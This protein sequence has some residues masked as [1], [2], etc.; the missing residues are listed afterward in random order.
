M[1]VEPTPYRCVIPGRL[2]QIF[3]GMRSTGP[4]PSVLYGAHTGDQWSLHRSAER[5]RL[6][7]TEA[8][9]AA[10]HPIPGDRAQIEYRDSL[11]GHSSKGPV[12]CGARFRLEARRTPGGTCA[13]AAARTDMEA[14][15]TP[16]A[17]RRPAARPRPIPPSRRRSFRVGR[18]R[19]VHDR[20]R[21]YRHAATDT[22]QVRRSHPASITFPTG[23]ADARKRPALECH[24][25][26]PP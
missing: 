2:S 23:I 11:R 24:R 9:Q 22:C 20:L 14:A 15:Q 8:A 4:R 26:S 7:T 6:P 5:R 17:H 25:L 21:P 12:K 3:V 1:T 13:T 16:H 19:P 10:E 18:S